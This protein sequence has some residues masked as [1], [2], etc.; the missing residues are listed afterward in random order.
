MSERKSNADVASRRH[1]LKLGAMAAPAV[2]TLAP[3]SARAAASVLHCY[4]PFPE[5]VNE[6]GE[7]C[8]PTGG[9]SQQAGILGNG[10]GNGPGNGRGP[11]N[12]NGP[13]NGNGRGLGNGN[14]NGQVKG[15][16]CYPG[17]DGGMLHAEQIR[18][19]YG[20]E[21]MTMEPEHYTAYVEYLDRVRQE[22]GPGVS[23][24]MSVDIARG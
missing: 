8:S 7:P 18:N 3:A 20:V 12:G 1:L 16:I 10:N 23:C 11:A 15:E 6:R 19:G 17:P 22:N 14:S 4:V 5:G 13:G 24:L 9:A 2:I 21:G